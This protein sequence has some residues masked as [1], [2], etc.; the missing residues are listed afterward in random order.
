MLLDKYERYGIRGAAVKWLQT[1]HDI[2][3]KYIEISQIYEKL[4]TE[5]YFYISLV[6]SCK[7]VNM[8][9]CCLFVKGNVESDTT[10]L[11]VRAFTPKC[12]RVSRV[13]KHVI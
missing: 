7:A 8:D 2:R 11:P 12:L 1:H 13:L 3:N 6:A 5:T 4:G 10:Q 9:L